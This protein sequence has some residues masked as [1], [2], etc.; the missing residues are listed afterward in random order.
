M[1]EEGVPAAQSDEEELAVP[2]DGSD[3]LS[4]KLGKGT[5]ADRAQAFLR[6]EVDAIDTTAK[7]ALRQ[8]A[9]DGLHFRQLGH[10]GADT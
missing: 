8:T 3:G 1:H 9:T 7:D 10:R 2:V 6:P 4:L 5:K